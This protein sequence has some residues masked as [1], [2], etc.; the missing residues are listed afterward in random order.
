MLISLPCVAQV[1]YHETREIDLGRNVAIDSLAQT[2]ASAQKEQDDHEWKIKEFENLFQHLEDEME[3][4][5]DCIG[6][7]WRPG[8]LI[9][10]LRPFVT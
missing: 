10:Q 9:G 3:K 7:F 2:A 6:R 4:T 1:G 8:Y 5:E